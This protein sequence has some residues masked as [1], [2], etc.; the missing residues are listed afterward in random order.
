[1]S[2]IDR[3]NVIVRARHIKRTLGTRSAAGYCRNRHFSLNE[4]LQTLG[5]PIRY[6]A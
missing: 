1:M 2:L 4:A 6:S 3:L 5:F